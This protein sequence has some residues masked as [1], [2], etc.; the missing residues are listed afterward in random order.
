MVNMTQEGV[1][2][3][4]VV[5]RVAPDVGVDTGKHFSNVDANVIWETKMQASVRLSNR[6]LVLCI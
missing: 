6:N 4:M 1:L 3:L 2:N 5:G